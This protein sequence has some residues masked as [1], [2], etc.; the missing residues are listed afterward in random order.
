MAKP[1]MAIPI[2]KTQSFSSIAIY[3][4][5]AHN[6]IANILFVPFLLPASAGPTDPRGQL[7]E[8]L[9]LAI[10]FAMLIVVIISNN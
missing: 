6:G 3:K 10:S 7:F 9:M 2:L 5:N 8:T 1:Y 4:G